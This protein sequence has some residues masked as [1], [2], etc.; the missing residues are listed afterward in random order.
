MRLFYVFPSTKNTAWVFPVG[1]FAVHYLARE[2]F[3]AL[4]LVQV[5]RLYVKKN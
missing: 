4:K 5:Y 2:L 1:L 3:M